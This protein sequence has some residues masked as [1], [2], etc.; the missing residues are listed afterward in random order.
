MALL[1][2]RDL[3]VHFATDDGVVKAVDGVNFSLDPG[4]T[5]GIVGES[6]SGK[7]VSTLTLMGL[8][9]GARISGRRCSRAATCS[10]MPEQRAA[11]GPRRADRHD[12]P[13]PAVQPAP[14]STGSGGR[15][16][17]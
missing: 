10:T 17:R 11:R 8:S 5:L 16:P 15:S 2:V 12:L 6:G 4:Q 14:A 3:R 1:E 7:S 9:R 13:G